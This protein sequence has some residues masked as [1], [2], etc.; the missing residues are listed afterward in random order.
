MTGTGGSFTVTSRDGT[1]IAGTV[2]GKG[3]PVVL[4]HGTSGSDFSWALVR[5]HLEGRHTVCAVQRRG[6]GHSGDGAEY[7]LEAGGG[8]H[9]SGGRLDRRACGPGR[10]LVRRE[11]LPG[12]VPA[13]DERGAA[14]ALRT[15]S[16]TFPRTAHRHACLEQR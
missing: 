11:L 7:C 14:R 15:T 9:R 3:P 6:R 12:G 10:S 5:P 2:T 16:S 1:T 8:G 13:D 4:V